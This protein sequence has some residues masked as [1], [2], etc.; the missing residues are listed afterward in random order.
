MSLTRQST[1]KEVLVEF[2]ARQS[3][4]WVSNTRRRHGH[5]ER[6]TFPPW[7]P[8]K[9][10]VEF[11]SE[12]VLALIEHW[13]TRCPRSIPRT[14]R[15]VTGI[16]SYARKEGLFTFD[17]LPTASW[18]VPRP[19]DKKAN[20][21][22]FSP[23]EFALLLRGFDKYS[24]AI[25]EPWQSACMVGYYT[26]LRHIDVAYLRWAPSGDPHDPGTYVDF[27]EEA[28]IAHP[29]K[30]RRFGQRLEIP[31]EPEL[32]EHLQACTADRR[33]DCPWV[34][35]MFRWW[36]ENDLHQHNIIFRNVCKSIGLGRNHCFHSFRYG[37][38][39]RLINAGVNPIVIS[40]MTGQSLSTIQTYSQVS[41]EA[42]TV[43]LS[44]ARA[45]LHAA[46]ATSRGF[47]Q[48]QHIAL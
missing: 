36:F 8:D 35:P 10:I 38:V 18:R 14:L 6:A 37:F 32:Y 22:A 47:R 29:V 9:P 31:I 33:Q 1:I 12:D 27:A 26:G 24:M 46:R 19:R 45:A 15:W 42:K 3:P 17:N 4:S 44:Q 5:F 13:K 30:M 23:E 21:K 25:S 43:A 16:F 34:N 28:I 48:P 11:R 20:R 7:D 39:S 2:Q 41:M 40:S